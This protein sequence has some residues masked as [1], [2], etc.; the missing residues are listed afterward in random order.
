M[1]HRLAGIPSAVDYDTITTFQHP[2][3]RRNGSSGQ[4]HFAQHG[5]IVRLRLA[6]SRDDPLRHNEHVHR[7]LR[8]HVSNRQEGFRFLYDFCWYFSGRNSFKDGHENVYI[9]RH[10]TR[11]L[12]LSGIFLTLLLFLGSDGLIERETHLVLARCK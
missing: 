1:R 2:E 12:L 5:G 10:G 3:L 11:S 6:E 9:H 7:R 4:Q 8:I